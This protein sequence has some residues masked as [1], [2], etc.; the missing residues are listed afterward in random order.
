MRR[1]PRVS[2]V[3]RVLGFCV[4]AVAVAPDVRGQADASRFELLS[5]TLAGTAGGFG[6]ST[7][8]GYNAGQ[9]SA[10]NRLAVFASASNALVL[11]D[12]N[13]HEDVFV[14]DRQAGVTSLVSVSSSGAQANGASGAAV[15]SANGRYVAFVSAATNLV[16]LDTNDR[17]DVFV[18]DLIART[19][20]IINISSASVQDDSGAAHPTI[21]ADGRYV[22]FN[23]PA[24]TLVAGGE[25]NLWNSD[26][27]VRDRLLA[28]TERVSVRPDGSPII[29]GDSMRA[30]ISGD[31]RRIAFVVYDNTLAGPTPFVPSN[32][33]NGIY[34]RDLTAAETTLVSARPDGTPSDRLPAQDPMISANGRFVVFDDWEDLDP[35]HPDTAEE[36]LLDG[37]FSDT[38]VRDLQLHVTERISLPY[39]GGPVEE[40]SSGIP[41]ISAD[42]RF[43]SYLSR[44]ADRVNIRDRAT[45]TT[46][47][48]A[49]SGFDGAR[50]S[51]PTL[52]PDGRQLFVEA[53]SDLVPNDTNEMLDYYVYRLGPFADLSL[54]L[55]ST[56]AQP[57]LG[58]DATFSIGVTNGGP[59]DASGVAI[60][61][62]L[63]P[64]LS[65]VS[66]TGAGAY[67]A[68]TGAW[69]IGALPSGA[70]TALQVV[71]TFT[72]TS[73]THVTAQVSGASPDDPDSTPGND[74]PTEDDQHTIQLTPAIADLSIQVSANTATPPVRSNV[75]LTATMTNSGPATASGVSV[76]ALMPAGLTFVSATPAAQYDRNTGTWAVG[77]IPNGGMPALRIV[78]RV[79]TANAIDMT[80]EIVASNQP[81]PDSTPGNGNGAED[82]QHTLP[83]APVAAVG[84]V[85]NDAIAP[86]DPN[87]GR[88]TLVEAIVAANTDL[89]SGNALGECV[90]GDGADAIFLRALNGPQELTG[91]RRYDVTSIHNETYGAQWPAGD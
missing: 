36:E 14:R 20:E 29:G 25:P 39:P 31:G 17:I 54:T 77:S 85:V 32:L 5:V 87:D 67:S 49:G 71:G 50:L 84:I 68:A 78:A 38:F 58:S 34:V 76:R 9:L 41:T 7:L 16:P 40:S 44:D 62:A 81:D 48:I 70:T 3:F 10:D 21:S 59:D 1:K 12:A 89:P 66:D 73:V 19:T 27:F 37:P 79:T 57:A 18:R 82:D 33:H 30:S 61:L 26:V 51:F 91:A 4:L 60:Q 90:G 75:T 69:S 42:G 2:V 24:S 15:I 23:S 64:G 45:A 52:S 11:G 13:G 8:Y 56:T 35:N 43:V 55:S 72:A 53:Y 47:T 28:T 83:I 6:D 22:A 65:F 80:G 88:C 74:N 63:P 46:T 86:V